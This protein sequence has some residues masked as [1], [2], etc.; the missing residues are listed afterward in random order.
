MVERGFWHCA[1][2]RDFWPDGNLANS[3]TAIIR[4][5]NI[6][7]PIHRHSSGTIKTRHYCWAIARPPTSNPGERH[8]IATRRDLADSVVVAIRHIHSPAFIH[9]HAVGIIETRRCA[10]SIG[11]T[12]GSRTCQRRHR[13]T[14]SDLSYQV[15]ATIRHIHI[16]APIHRNARG[17]IKTRRCPLS[18]G[19]TD[20]SRTRQRRY[21]TTG[22]DLPDSIVVCISHIHIPAPFHCN[23]RGITKTRSGSLP[24]GK[25]EGS[26][27]C[28]RRHRTTKRDFADSEVAAIRH[29][30]I[31]AP[32]HRN[33][34]GSI[35]ARRG[36]LS[37]G[38]EIPYRPRQSRHTPI[39]R[40]LAD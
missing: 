10:L 4:H 38:I 32:I 35:E 2:D 13:T 31:P 33:A 20:G 3:A 23:T 37:I 16:P 12:N 11:R 26:R 28:Q 40:D 1:V 14:R 24:I 7:A 9:C 18:V 22:T 15:I 29:I 25:S 27:T 39:R 17:I 8:H 36:S 30:H 21:S 6:P 5:I 19:R 34:R